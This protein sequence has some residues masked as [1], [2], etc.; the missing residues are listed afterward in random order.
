MSPSDHQNRLAVVTG[1]GR[2][3]GRAYAERLAAD[4]ARIVV[5]DLEPPE[6]TVAAIGAAATPAVAD[7]S[8]P[9]DVEALAEQVAALGGADILVHNAGI[10]PMGPVQGIDFEEWRRVFAVNLDSLFLLS[11]AFLPHMRE[12]GWGRIVGV[13]SA[14]FHLGAPGSLHYVASKG[15]VIGFV[16]AL[17]TEVGPDGVTVNAIAPGLIRSPGTSTGLHDELGLF[18]MVIE[19]QAIKRTG[20]PE[21]LTGAMSFL[22]SDDAAYI[23]GQTLVV[24]GGTARG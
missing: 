17:A 11:Q 23:T 1:A 2:G 3:I 13:S 21:D 20:M 6:E 8:D 19:H 22:V 4:G 12:Q 24:D 18:E 16:R 7:V 15:G 14:M 5:A 10:Y 9:A